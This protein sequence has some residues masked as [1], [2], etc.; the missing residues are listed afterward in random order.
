MT[1]ETL[2]KEQEEELKAK[3]RKISIKDG[4]AF[5][6]MDGM[7]LRY[8]TPYA[9]RLGANNA[10]IGFLT[11]IPSLIGNFLQMFASKA[12]NKYSRKKIILF[13]VFFQALMW[14][15]L[16]LIGYMF[17]Y[18][19]LNQ[20]TS[21]NLV[22]II[23]SLIVIFGAFL[24]P[25]WNSLMRD[26]VTKNTG[27]YFGRRNR[28]VGAF[29]LVSL[30]IGSFILDYFKKTN[31]FIGF[32]IIFVIAFFAR[33][34][35]WLFLKK[36]YEPELK[37]QK[38]YFFSF[39]QFVSKIPQSNFGKFALFVALMMLAT[40]IAAPF[41]SVY[42]LK[43]LRF[44]YVTWMLVTI[45]SSITSI[46]FMPLWGKVADKYGNLSVIRVSSAFIPFVALLWMASPLIMRI[47]PIILIIY[48]LLIECM[49]G[50]VWAGFNL[51]VANFVF[52][53][54]TRERF[55][56]CIAYSNFLNGLGIFIGATIGGVISSLN[57]S[58]GWI[59]PLIF[60]FILSGVAR[61]MVYVLMIPGIKEVRRVEIGNDSNI[62]REIRTSFKRE[63]KE[64]VIEL[65]SKLTK[66]WS[67]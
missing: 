48:L 13:G 5:G 2:S 58:F 17:F 54:V 15:P 4:S 18:R 22:V 46:I 29:V 24:A 66:P 41:F 21:S 10:Q 14:L 36:H 3:T 64:K 33:T 44:N 60:I 19:D 52:D 12:M 67:G 38:G 30:L 35:S 51:S 63:I 65:S 7:G 6:I 32:L 1:N 62:G 40:S 31:V 45:A 47:N 25:T 59:S 16:I 55:P 11:S 39:K 49:S 50:I 61:T 43:E 23:Y 20:S 27:A 26:V 9:L 37:L 42:M 8:I 34:I 56:L 53:A 57:F 28:I